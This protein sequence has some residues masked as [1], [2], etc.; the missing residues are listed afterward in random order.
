MRY[1]RLI[2][3]QSLP[4]STQTALDTSPFHSYESEDGTV[5]TE[6]H[7]ADDGYLL[8]FPGMA[9][10][11]VSA[12][13]KQVRAHPVTGINEATVEH[14]YINQL[15]PL[16]LSRQGLPAYH[17]SAVTVPGGAVAFLGRTG[18]GKSTLA[19]S[20]ALGESAFLTDDG[21]IIEE[22]G[23]GYVALPSHAS[24]RLWDDS[25]EALAGHDLPKAASISYSD[26]TRL[27]AGGALA[28]SDEAVPL[29]AAFQLEIDEPDSIDINRLDGGDRYRA[30]L[31][32]SFL[33]D[34]EDQSLLARHFDWTHRISSAI[35]TYRLDYRRNFCILPEV[36]RAIRALVAGA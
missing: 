22:T 19:A 28:H 32:N 30:W 29:L 10:F 21:L 9:D 2:E 18:A 26:K 12:D 20:F 27:L 11:S 14:L 17:A 8:R 13:G 4:A 5:W 1:E 34:I 23:R 7:R 31:E 24:V 16:A 3:Y 15:V 25:V 33:L 6:F 36:R 35:P